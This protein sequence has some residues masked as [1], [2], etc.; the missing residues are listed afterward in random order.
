[1][2]GKR[3]VLHLMVDDDF[4]DYFIEQSERLFP[5]EAKYWVVQEDGREIKKVKSKYV[6]GIYWNK[7]NFSELSKE[8]NQY[9][10]IIVHSFFISNL[11]SFF[12]KLNNP[13]L[14]W[15][16]W[17]GDGYKYSINNKQ[18]Y[19][20]ITQKYRQ[21]LSKNKGLKGWLK[22]VKLTWIDWQNS[23]EARWLIK[24]VNVCATWVKYDYE[25]I[26]HINPTLKWT[27][28][29]Y[30][31]CQQ[32]GFYKISYQPLNTNRLWLGNSATESNNHLDA[33]QDLHA[34]KWEG[35][36]IVP[37]S[38]G[39]SEYAAVVKE[40]GTRYFG[41]KIIFLENWMTLEEYH[42]RMNN[43]GF[44]WMNHIRQQAAGTVLGALYMGKA[45]IMNSSSNLYKTLND[46]GVKFAQTK[47][48]KNIAEIK[49]ENFLHNRSV[50]EKQLALEVNEEA[51][52]NM[53]NFNF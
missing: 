36:I 19:L 40:I 45:V 49:E 26:R 10:I 44:V 51:V 5:L 32:L 48:L 46:W 2:P 34:M 53:Y 43:C 52:R 41:H 47:D 13:K 8:A 31:T 50:I 22:R 1:M 27:S 39:N 3:K 30:F 4:I 9:D 21:S 28:Y 37:I 12:K 42:D 29:S 35:E 38:Y 11:S 18:W 6:K 33:L 7:G 24:R 17:G 23:K 25:M 20:P 14:V 15:L 16:F